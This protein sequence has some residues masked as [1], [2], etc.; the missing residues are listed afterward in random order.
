M[1]ILMMVLQ[2]GFF[3]GGGGSGDGDG[4][5]GVFNKNIVQAAL[6]FQQNCLPEIHIRFCGET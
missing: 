5:G 3:V 2:G 1:C 4:G 6:E